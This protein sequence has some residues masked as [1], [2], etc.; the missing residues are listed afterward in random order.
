MSF[1]TPAMRAVRTLPRPATTNVARCTQQFRFIT[2]RPLSTR[3]EPNSVPNAP[4]SHA[5]HTESKEGGERIRIDVQDADY[6]RRETARKRRIA[7]S[8]AGLM[9]CWLGLYISTMYVEDNP[10]KPVQMDSGLRADDPLVVLGKEKK[11]VVQKLGEEPEEV[12]DVVETGTS[13]VPTFPRV[14]EF[15]DND[16]SAETKETDL[17]EY[18]L[19]GLGIRTVSFLGIQVYVVGMYVATEDIAILQEKL[20]R[21]I[22]PIATTLV[23]GEKERLKELLKDPVQGEEIWS[24]VLKD[25]GVRTM[26]RIVPTRDTD[27]HH[28]R[29][30]WVRCVTGRAQKNK[31]EYGDDAFGRA[32][33]EF[34][35]LFNRGS[36][37]KKKEMLLLRDAKGKLAVWYDAGKTGPQRVG[38]IED[39][40]ISRA[41]WLNYLAGKTVASESARQSIIEGV[42]EFV[43]RPVGTVATQ[44]QVH[45]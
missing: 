4:L 41:I 24:T 13:T 28:M 32:V 26:V 3:K 30:A 37:P 42:L 1:R 29:D 23:A 43:E 16:G 45:V 11:V 10:S 44:V 17:V 36:V 19:M 9:G 39:E 35:A 18:Q 2:G 22:D 20:I 5:M 14:L 27:F 6:E 31:E 12:P 21:K 38:A 34:K 40:R 8:A 33:A 25:S 15:F 7:T